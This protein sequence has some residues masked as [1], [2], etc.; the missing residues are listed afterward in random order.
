MAISNELSSEI[1]AAILA[2]KKTPQ[3]LRQL[4]DVIL[5]VHS[6]LQ[7]MSEEVRATR[8]KTKAASDRRVSRFNSSE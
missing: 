1:A 2:E 3:E 6:A 4:K 7:E 5:R 8:L